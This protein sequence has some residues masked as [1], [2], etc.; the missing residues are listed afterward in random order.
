MWE[1]KAPRKEP[2][3]SH[4]LPTTQRG[5]VGVTAG[6]TF[7]YDSVHN[8]PGWVQFLGKV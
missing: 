4:V 6:L 3:S 7:S 1:L 2:S 8:Q 5:L